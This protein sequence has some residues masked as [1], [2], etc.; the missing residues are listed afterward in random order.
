MKE[1][2][3]LLS[4]IFLVLVVSLILFSNSLC[5]I[6]I[7]LL[8]QTISFG[9]KVEIK[10]VTVNETRNLFIYLIEPEFART[11]FLGSINGTTTKILSFFPLKDYG[12]ENIIIE[13]RDD[14]NNSVLVK[15]Y[16]IFIAKARSLLI[17]NVDREELDNQIHFSISLKNIG[18]TAASLMIMVE[19]INFEERIIY[20]KNADVGPGL[21]KN[22]D[23]FIDYENILANRF[24]KLRLKIIEINSLEE[25]YDNVFSIDREG[26]FRV[27]IENNSLIVYSFG[28]YTLLFSAK[29]DDKEINKTLDVFY[30]VNKF[31]LRDLTGYEKFEGNISLYLGPEKI[32]E[33]KIKLMEEKKFISREIKVPMNILIFLAGLFIF[34]VIIYLMRKQFIEPEV[35]KEGEEEEEL[36]EAP[37]LEEFVKKIRGEKGEEEKVS[38]EGEEEEKYIEI[39]DL[40]KPEEKKKEEK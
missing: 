31:A 38:T 27:K 8:N 35:K 37:T 3:K 13:V 32:Y 15:N 6:D 1:S 14:Y 7:T 23:I 2:L 12:R 40:V 25:I 33:S 28:N 11:R 29:F 17:T 39:E 36:G 34:A 24:R 18:S 19:G 26:I 20:R 5:A 4:R 30:G 10:V 16:T 21:K 22:L 9:E